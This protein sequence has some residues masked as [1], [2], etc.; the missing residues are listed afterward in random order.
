MGGGGVK[1]FRGWVGAEQGL[2]SLGPL[3]VTTRK[4][5]APDVRTGILNLTGLGVLKALQESPDP[6]P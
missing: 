6:K 1:G 3:A 4:I 2:Q 5:N